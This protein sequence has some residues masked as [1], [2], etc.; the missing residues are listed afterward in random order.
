MRT[1]TRY[2]A[3]LAATL[4]ALAL[5]LTAG[6]G[7]DDLVLDDLVEKYVDDPVSEKSG[8]REPD[9]TDPEMRDLYKAIMSKGPCATAPEQPCLDA[10]AGFQSGGDRLATYLIAQFEA[11]AADERRGSHA[12]L[13]RIAYT[14]GPDSSLGCEYLVARVDADPDEGH[15]YELRDEFYLGAVNALRYCK[16]R[17][18]EVMRAAMDAYNRWPDSRVREGAYH[19][20]RRNGL[21]RGGVERDE[22]LELIALIVADTTSP[23]ELRNEAGRTAA[24]ATGTARTIAAPEL[25]EPLVGER[26][27]EAD[28]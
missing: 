17:P 3:T 10:L 5:P 26:Q 22:A 24:D 18:L 8:V 11:S 20:I 12:L 1:Q 9:D 19:A 25:L 16:S 15:A 23:A 21:E 13:K 27:F 4:L 14:T 2:T 28:R 6:A 7:A